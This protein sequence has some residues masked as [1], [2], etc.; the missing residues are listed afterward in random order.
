[1]NNITKLTLITNRSN[2]ALA[3]YLLFIEQCAQAGITALQLREK[4]ASFSTLKAFGKALKAILRPFNV[5][6]IINDNID[7]AI[8]LDAEGVHLGQTDGCPFTARQRLGHEKIIGVSIDSVDNLLA[9][10]DQPIDYVGIGAIFPTLNKPNVTTHWGIEGLQTIAPASKHP[11]IAIGGI[12]ES[13]A[14][15]VMLS[16]AQ[17]IAVIGAVHDAICPALTLQKLRTIVDYQGNLS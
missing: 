12:T 2:I 16:G 3:D 1:M 14:A 6:L 9:A 5:P 13:N 15:S 8:E 17:G 4:N 10:N 11:M 7:L